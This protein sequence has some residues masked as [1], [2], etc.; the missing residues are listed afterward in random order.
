MSPTAANGFLWQEMSTWS[1]ATFLVLLRPHC[2][3]SLLMRSLFSLHLHLRLRPH[4]RRRPERRLQRL[5]RP[6]RFTSLMPRLRLV[7]L[8]PPLRD[9]CPRSRRPLNCLLGLRTC[10]APAFCACGTACLCTYVMSFLSYM[11]HAGRLKPS[12]GLVMPSSTTRTCSPLP[13][14]ISVL[15]T[16]C[17]FRF[18]C[19]RGPSLWRPSPTASTPSCRRRWMLSSTNTW[20]LVSSSTP[21]PLGLLPLW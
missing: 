16:S 10:N 20:P 21:L 17:L 11:T 9:R 13:S 18:L 19:R 1:P 14:L 12:T 15:A 8:L 6:L 2:C 5:R 7:F 4:R 3:V